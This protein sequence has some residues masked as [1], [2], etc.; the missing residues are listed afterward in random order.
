MINRR[1]LI[2]DDELLTAQTIRSIAEFASF[3]VQLTTSP[4]EFFQILENWQPHF[5]AIDLIM[6]GMDGLEVMAELAR[7]QC[8]SRIIITS[9]VGNRVLDAAGRSASE[10]G[11][12]IGGVLPKPFTPASLRALLV[13]QLPEKQD[14]E[15]KS[16]PGPQEPMPDRS[17][18]GIAE[19]HQALLRNELF[20]MY[21]PK[22]VCQSGMLAGFEALVRWH[23]P[24]LGELA[25]DLFIPLAENNGLIDALTNEV[26]RQSLDWFSEFCSDT[27]SGLS[28]D[29]SRQDLSRLTLSINISA[30]SLTNQELF[31][32]LIKLCRSKNIEPQRLIFELTETSAMEDPVLSLDLLTRLRMKGFRL[33]I[34]DFGTGFSSMLQLVRLPFSEVKVD[35]SFVITARDSEESRAVIKSIVDLSHSLGLQTIAEG[36]ETEE[37]LSYLKTIGC[38]LAQGYF[39]A[40]PMLAEQ[41]NAWLLHQ[42]PVQEVQRQ[43]GLYDVQI[44]D[45]SREI[46]F[47]RLMRLARRLFDIPAAVISLVDRDHQWFKSGSGF[48]MQGLP[49]DMT[50]CNHAIISDEV[51]IVEDASVDQR[52]ARN[53]L[54]T[55][56]PH[57]RFYAGCPLQAMD[58]NRIGLLCLID[59]VAR[60]FSAADISILSEL[61]RL[62][63]YELAARAVDINDPQ[64]QL[65]NQQ[66]FEIRVP[67]VLTLCRHRP[68]VCV[69]LLF[70]LES[71]PDNEND[72]DIQNASPNT[73]A[74]EFAALLQNSF[75]GSDFIAR[76]AD[77]RFAALLIGAN[78]EHGKL[79]LKRLTARLAAHAQANARGERIAFRLGISESDPEQ[80][81]DLSFLLARA[82]RRLHESKVTYPGTEISMEQHV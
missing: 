60:S 57:I 31:E 75:R 9:G 36:I 44:L 43:T 76:L 65:L 66:G 78:E 11:L 22:I 16:T 8:R 79:A 14:P 5:V 50:F 15:L 72:S 61:S 3:D 2:L 63:E 25:P 19:L 81:E 53:P 70:Q 55:K 69:L 68:L 41:V 51:L 39:I 48:N 64:T 26:F 40:R 38:D 42:E 21:Q 80:E 20:V 73:Q 34:D 30:L 13:D 47:R 77:D 82:E 74:V 52:F 35:K 67:I 58:G 23:H 33:S 7:R 1:L 29:D 18:I 10:H 27:R 28:P 6:P 45:I 59:R 54:V 46:R 62:V 49:D 37:S 32:G 71:V 12:N 56:E 17:E 24:R 4:E